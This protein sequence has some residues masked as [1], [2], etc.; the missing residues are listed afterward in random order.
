MGEDAL[1]P[2]ARDPD[3]DVRW[4][5]IEALGHGMRRAIEALVTV[6]E[7]GMP[8][9]AHGAHR[10]REND[11]RIISE[12]RQMHADHGFMP[13]DGTKEDRLLIAIEGGSAARLRALRHCGL[14]AVV[15]RKT[16]CLPAGRA[17]HGLMAASCALPCAH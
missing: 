17:S 8:G 14:L 7:T 9:E 1:L 2:L 11:R 6:T 13:T 10:P 16:G 15:A 12:D 5:A 4:A 3:P